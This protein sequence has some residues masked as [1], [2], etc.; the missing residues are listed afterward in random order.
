MEA[1]RE[2][3]AEVNKTD[4]VIIHFQMFFVLIDIND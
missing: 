4:F 2:R 1:F 3:D